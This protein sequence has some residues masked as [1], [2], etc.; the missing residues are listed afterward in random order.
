MFFRYVILSRAD[1]QLE[2]VMREVHLGTMFALSWPLT[3]FSHSLNHYQ[4]V[5]AIV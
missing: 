4:Q 2:R 5:S 1:P 3:W